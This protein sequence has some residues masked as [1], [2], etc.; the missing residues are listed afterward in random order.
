MQRIIIIEPNLIKSFG[1][2][3]EFPTAISAAAK[4][5]NLEV[6][7]ISN[8]NITEEAL[9]EL[10]GIKIIKAISNT[11]FEQIEDQGGVFCE[12]LE[13]VHEEIKFQN[14]DIILCT[15]SYTNQLY[16][17]TKFLNKHAIDVKFNLW[18]HQIYPPQKVFNALLAKDLR[19]EL[20]SQLQHALSFP[21]TKSNQ[22]NIF[23]TEAIELGD[24]F[25]SN[26]SGEVN[27]LPLPFN[28]SYITEV[29]LRKDE[30]IHIGFLGDGRYEKG[31]LLLLRLIDSIRNE[32]YF[33]M[34][35]FTLQII[36]PRGYSDLEKLEFNNL[37]ESLS[38]IKNINF[39]ETGL[40]TEEYYSI[41]RDQ[42]ILIFPYNPDSYDKRVS[43]IFL[44]S[45]SMGIPSIVSNNT[46]LSKVIENTLPEVIFDYDTDY[47]TTIE[48]MKQVMN[49]IITNYNIFK[50]KFINNA[51][52]FRS[53][54][55]ASYFLE[56]I[57]TYV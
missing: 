46:W 48:N 13:K 24:F 19:L 34:L 53:R 37:V 42:N 10:N 1:H 55:N 7:V 32:K 57:T 12:D 3:I 41:F 50:Q 45:L 11:C 38:K 17:A 56:E 27:T 30:F 51:T 54:N 15:T 52:S 35:K 5:L 16:G 39:I 49:R 21:E 28:N 22:I 40:S 47:L 6:L 18:F 44:Q 26:Y 9:K 33:S 25:K 29:P 31:A 2:V 8:K 14:N 23:T 4:K 43:A 36:N 20:E